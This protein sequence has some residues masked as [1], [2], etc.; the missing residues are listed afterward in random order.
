MASGMG[1]M[2]STDSF[3]SGFGG[4]GFGGGDFGGGGFGGGDF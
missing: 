2:D 4:G 3:N 1:G